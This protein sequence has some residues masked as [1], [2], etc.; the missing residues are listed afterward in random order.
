[1]K[2]N[3]LRMTPPPEPYR[4]IINISASWQE[5]AELSAF[6]SGWHGPSS[7]VASNGPPECPLCDLAQTLRTYLHHS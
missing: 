4:Y 2:V 6:V 7:H 1:M 3:I 5:L